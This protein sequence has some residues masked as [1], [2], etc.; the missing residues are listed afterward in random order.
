M[1]IAVHK[2][3][4]SIPIKTLQQRVLE[5][6]GTASVPDEFIP[7]TTLGLTD[8][9]KLV[10][11]KIKKIELK[12]LV[13]DYRESSHSESSGQDEVDG[14]LRQPV[15]HIWSSLLGLR[16]EDIDV[17]VPIDRFADSITIMRFRDKLQKATS[18]TLS[19]R[20]SDF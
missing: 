12:A 2:S 6:L 8:W 11:G 5:K 4:H 10:N 18:T 7:I 20:R 17:N 16:E 9:P 3:N 1:P 15:L 19:S 14:G 13:R